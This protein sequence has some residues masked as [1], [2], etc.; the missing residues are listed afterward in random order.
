MTLNNFG[1]LYCNIQQ[2]DQVREVYKAA[3]H[4]V[5]SSYRKNIQRHQ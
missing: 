4:H 2:F 1:N 5:A 3:V